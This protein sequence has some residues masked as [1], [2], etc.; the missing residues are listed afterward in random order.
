MIPHPNTREEVS[1][2]L[3]WIHDELT[4]QEIMH[5]LDQDDD[6][7]NLWTV[8]AHDESGHV[9]LG[10]VSWNDVENELILIAFD[11]SRA[12]HDTMEGVPEDESLCH[13]YPSDVDMLVLH[14]NGGVR[15]VMNKYARLMLT[16]VAV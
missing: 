12:N 9:N 6:N 7:P 14:L 15:D 2:V 4:E 10:F 8:A 16:S 3:D 1:V 11:P 5:V 13:W